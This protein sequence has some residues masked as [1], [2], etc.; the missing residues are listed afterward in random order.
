MSHYDQ[1]KQVVH[2]QYNIVVQKNGSTIRKTLKNIVIDYQWGIRGSRSTIEFSLDN[3]HVITYKRDEPNTFML[4][5]DGRCVFRKQV[6]NPIGKID[7][8]FEI[9][10]I[11]CQFLCQCYVIAVDVRIRV[12][13]IEIFST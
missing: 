8:V 4:Y 2:N 3:E 6:F 13:G 10:G 12:A 7:Y 11:D 5:V 9:E 1:R